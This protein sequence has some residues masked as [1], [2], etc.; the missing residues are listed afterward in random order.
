MSVTVLL[1]HA[2]PVGPEMWEPQ[3]EALSGYET[4][5]PSLYGR[6]ESI[7]GWAEQLL[8]EIEGDLVVVGASMGGYC[9]LAIVRRAPER[10]KGLVL[11]GSHASAD[12]P[13]SRNW[14]EQAVGLI[15]QEGPEAIWEEMRP[16]A[17]S[18]DADPALVEKARAIVAR[19]PADGLVQAMVAI[20]ARPDSHD[21][22]RSL[23]CPLLAVVGE[24]DEGVAAESRQL[25]AEAPEAELVVIPGAAHL[26]SFER[27][28]AF[29]PVLL[30]FLE[31][32]R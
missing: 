20:G 26:V 29:D 11:A 31:R 27:P 24:L 12:A 1:L 32:L 2:F 21:L 9:G 15:M 18:P 4:K 16:A 14:R 28:E 13:E 7:D 17:L 3:L 5:A 25:V 6:G 23:A 30:R 19:Q 10:V 22:V 8:S